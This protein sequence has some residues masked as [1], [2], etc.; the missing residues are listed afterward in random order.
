ME[1]I[2]EGLEKAINLI[3]HLDA[4]LLGII[5]LSLKVSCLALLIA[6]LF[7]IPL[8][9]AVAMK[10]IPAKG[11]LISLMNTLM[12]LP[13]VVVGLFLY[14]MLSRS[15]PLGFFGLLYT[16]GAMIIAQTILAFP[17]VTSLSHSAIV[18]IDPIIRQAAMTLGASP[19][20]VTRT[21]ITEARYGIL[22]GI[23]AAFGRVI[24]EVGA[25]LIVGGNI[26]G[27]TRAMTTAIALETDKGN[28]ELALALGIIL[29]FVSL[30]IN[31]V[32]HII[33]R[34]GTVDTEQWTWA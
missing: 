24:A 4:E 13:S 14:L 32:L 31:I 29:L 18:S 19:R 16:P 30:L 34:K 20:Q 11:A 8:G 15:G 7:G 28:F 25:I 5:F 1:L 22:T 26:A 2:L 17:I 9:A 12:G 33:Q 27:L 10:R 21:V 6:T 3:L 23:V